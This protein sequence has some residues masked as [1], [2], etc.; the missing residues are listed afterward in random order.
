MRVAI[1]HDYLAQAGGAERVVEA[2]HDIWPDAPIYTSIY[3]PEATL[4]SFKTMDIR[5]SFLQKWAR[6]EKIHKFALPFYPAAFEQFDMSGYDVVLSSTTG[7]AK[8]VITGPETCHICYC[9]TPARFA[10]RYHEYIARGG[11][12]KTTRRILPWLV[13]RLRSWDYNSAQRVDSFVAN[14]FNTARRIHKY[15]GREADVV[16]APVDTRRFLP[17][18]NGEHGDY[19]L[20][21]A[22]LVGYKRVD[23]AVEACQ[24]LGLPLRVVGT[25]PDSRKLRVLAGPNTE[26]LGHCSD[27][28]VAELLANCRAFLFPGE[29]D[30]GIAPLEAMASGRPVIA[31]R[32]GGALETVVEGETGLFF[33]QQTPESLMDAVHRLDS[34]LVYP[35]RLRAHAERFDIC[36]FQSRLKSLVETR[37]EQ[38]RAIYASIAPPRQSLQMTGSGGR[39]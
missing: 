8:G 20:V 38:H 15:Y 6:R 28:Q 16:Y 19:L 5:T 27:T 30:F 25:G 31:F 11:Y 39:R 2:M 4:P 36:A 34:L 12:G 23:L 17:L 7:F 37:L 9:H 33:D 22:R 18:S 14:S 35:A 24:R 29:E 32:A 26:F 10:W 13:H 3:D 1:V 21:V